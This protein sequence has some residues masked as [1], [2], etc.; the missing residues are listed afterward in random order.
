MSKWS[1]F[2]CVLVILSSTSAFDTAA[3]PLPY[4][5]DGLALG[6]KVR[7]D[8]QAYW[9]YHCTP[10]DKFPGFTWCH[11]EKTETADRGVC[12]SNSILHDHDGTAVYVN[13]Y[14]E[15][16]F[17][18]ANDLR[19]EIDRLSAKFRER[20]REIRMPRREGLPDAIIAVWGKI[21]LEQLGASDV[22]IVASA[23]SV[24]GLLV[25]FLG[26][27][28]RS[29]QIGVPVYKLGGG[30]GF[31]WAA[32]F[33]EDGRGTLRFLT[34]DASQIALATVAQNSRVSPPERLPPK[35]AELL[36]PALAD[37]EAAYKRG[38]YATALRLWQPFAAQ[39]NAFAQTRLGWM[40]Q[41]GQG[42]PPDD[43]E[44][45]RWYRLAAEQRYALAQYN[46]GF[47]YQNGIGVPQD[48]N[49]AV[50][51]YRLAAE[52]GNAYAQSNL[53]TAGGV[54]RRTTKRR[55]S[56]ISALLTK[57]MPTRRTVSK[58]RTKVEWIFRK[59]TK[60]RLSGIGALLNKEKPTRSTT[61]ALCIKTGKV[62]RGTIRKPSSGFVSLL[63]KGSGRRKSSSEI[64]TKREEV[65]RKTI[66]KR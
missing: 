3:Q 40:Y 15:P 23:G 63:S 64:F 62:F 61:S 20:P 9:T 18:S 66:K 56:G 35:S 32:S 41:N 59:I 6:G 50:K 22:S 48:Q 17:F 47:A 38:D 46:L 33:N 25:S 4:V 44:A 11:K 14:I 13:C 8:S 31:L 60:K 21:E 29:A 7:F 30:P 2:V 65:R 45:I 53:G 52:Q 5:V 49:E 58:R 57:E 42:V 12:S 10:S 39:G 1:A 36:S 27:L 26:D 55:S 28:Q 37:A 34:I 43:K 24:K 16:A 54:S 19:A 51:W